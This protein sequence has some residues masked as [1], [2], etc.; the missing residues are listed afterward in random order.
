MAENRFNLVDEKWITVV[1]HEFVSLNDI[2]SNFELK[3]LGGNP[4]Q[5]ISITKLLLAIAQS[6]YTPK[7]IQD[8]KELNEKGI[9]EKS[10]EYLK[11]NKDCFWLYGEKPFLQMLSAIKAEKR[12]LSNVSIGATSGNTSMLFQN[13][14]EKKLIDAEK[15]R[16]VVELQN[17]AFYSKKGGIHATPAPA[18]GKFGFLHSFLLSSTILKTLWLNML[19]D[20]QIKK[21]PFAK[22]GLG[23]APWGKMPES[24]DCCVAKNLKETY[25]GRLVP[26]SRFFLL[27]SDCLYYDEGIDY[28]DY[29]FSSFDISSA[30]D[31]FGKKPR[32]ILVD[33]EKRPWRELTSLLSFSQKK[34]FECCQLIFGIEKAKNVEKTIGI[35]SGGLKVSLQTGEQFFS[36]RDD[37]V[38]SESYFSL[39]KDISIQ[40]DNLKLEMS[41]LEEIANIVFQCTKKFFYSMGIK[42]RKMQEN[43]AKQ[44]NNLF[45]QLAENHFQKLINACSDETLIKNI[46]YDLIKEAHKAYDTFCSKETSRQIDA[47]AKNRPKLGKYL[48]VGS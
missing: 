29:S 25:I 17:F 2:F 48:K 20:E 45:W 32:S 23:Q 3:A 8:W 12:I 28:P 22:K 14:I 27:D 19:T 15:A 35:W 26:I 16:L 30:V 34:G 4:A 24:K 11:K 40:L 21:I 43:Q 46:H 5:K 7:D 9:S 39:E 38:E 41:F 33:P 36:E 31:L 18:L 1:D 37:F 13:Q 44:A 42:R 10:L 47:W 6:A